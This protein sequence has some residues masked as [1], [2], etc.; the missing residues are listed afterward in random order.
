VTAYKTERAR[1]LN[2]FGDNVSA[3][4]KRRNLSQERLAEIA[5]LHRNEIGMIERGECE[6]GLFVLL[7]LANTLEVSLQGLAAGVPAPRERRSS[8]R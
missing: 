2:A 1:L 6:P 3:E 5:N 8:R 7:V 4:R